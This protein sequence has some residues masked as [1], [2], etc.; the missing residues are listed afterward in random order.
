MT[1]IPS[2]LQKIISKK[3]YGTFNLGSSSGISKFEFAKEIVKL[4]NLSTKY[5]VPFLSN[6]KIDERPY[7]TILD[8]NKIEKKLKIK[9][10]TI[11]KSIKMLS[12]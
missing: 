9:L 11:N 3:I 5:L 4:N 8:V 12:K 1:L 10:P 6:I 7:G 2:I